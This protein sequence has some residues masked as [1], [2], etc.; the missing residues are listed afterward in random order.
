MASAVAGLKNPLGSPRDFGTPAA[1]IATK[2]SPRVVNVFEAGKVTA[3]AAALG[4][5][6]PRAAAPA[7]L[8]TVP[9]DPRSPQTRNALWEPLHDWTKA[10]NA[11]AYPN[12]AGGEPGIVTLAGH[13]RIKK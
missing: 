2:N 9:R 12:Q 3:P 5:G 7:K 6:S 10:D 11:D 1:G 8:G 4:R 13:G